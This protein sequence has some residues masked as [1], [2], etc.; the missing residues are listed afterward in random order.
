[1]ANCSSSGHDWVFSQT[2]EERRS[3]ADYAG[4]SRYLKLRI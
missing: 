2:T 4:N 3:M 1:V